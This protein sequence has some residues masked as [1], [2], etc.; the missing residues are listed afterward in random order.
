M[1]IWENFVQI[2]RFFRIFKGKI[3]N[4]IQLLWYLFDG[5]AGEEAGVPV[6]GGVADVEAAEDFDGG[7]LSKDRVVDA[8]LGPRLLRAA[9]PTTPQ[10][11]ALLIAQW[12]L[13][14]INTSIHLFT[15]RW[16]S[17][18]LYNFEGFLGILEE[19]EGKFDLFWNNFV[20]FMES[21]IFC[22]NNVAD[23]KRIL[24]KFWD[25]LGF[26]GENSIILE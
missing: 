11:I 14:F 7:V 20:N 4:W 3:I 1:E 13:Q 2:S 19:L 6:V 24:G 10:V 16:F 18:E 17:P 12:R 9:T 22:C 23:F 5:I 21:W 8:V 25:F 26:L 15:Y